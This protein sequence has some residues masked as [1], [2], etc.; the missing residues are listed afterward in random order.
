MLDYPG[1]ADRGRGRGRLT[2]GAAR[3]ASVA[4]RKPATLG[5]HSTRDTASAL[6]K[7]ARRAERFNQ[8]TQGHLPAQSFRL[9]T[10]L[11]ELIW[12]R[13][14]RDAR[15]GDEEKGEKEEEKKCPHS[16]PGRCEPAPTQTIESARVNDFS[17]AQSPP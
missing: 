7:T 15:T 11:G 10:V 12:A 14:Q 8:C 4:T 17:N 5:A 16:E 2:R 13:Q 9:L 3:A 6:G 1:R